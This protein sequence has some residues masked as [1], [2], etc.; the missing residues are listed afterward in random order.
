MNYYTKKG[1]ITRRA[2]DIILTYPAVNKFKTDEY[3]TNG[4]I[5]FNREF[6]LNCNTNFDKLSYKEDF[7]TYIDKGV[8]RENI[9]QFNRIN[10]EIKIENFKI[11]IFKNNENEIL[12]IDA[13]FARFL[14]DIVFTQFG[15]IYKLVTDTP[16]KNFNVGVMRINPGIG[17]DISTVLRLINPEWKF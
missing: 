7:K 9:T 15:D 17:S 13:R 2:Y 8:V 14:P 1:I 6:L 10:A 3:L 4:N 16:C 5:V 12:C 11:V